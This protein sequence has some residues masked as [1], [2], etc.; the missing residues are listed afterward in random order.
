MSSSI[1]AVV[2]DLGKVLL[3]FDYGRASSQLGQNS[4]LPTEEI[5]RHLDQSPLLLAYECGSMT[6]EE[7]IAEVTRRIGY[8]GTAATFAE[9]FGDIFTEIPSMVALHASI[10]AR[11]PTYLFSNTN[12]MAVRLVTRTFPF[13]SRFRGHVL[14]YEHASMKPEPRIYEVVERL[15]GAA[16]PEIA[17]IDDRLENVEAGR[18]RGWNVVL[19]TDLA[20]TREALRSFGVPLS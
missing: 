4:T 2:F 5:R 1:R 10:S 20:T 6:T 9:Q 3:E 15:S 17:Y 13:F 11:M 8:T 14:S 12:E 16:G 7:F 19:H 18:A